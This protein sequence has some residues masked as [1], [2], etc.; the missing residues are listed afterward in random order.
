MGND[1]AQLTLSVLVLVL[2]AGLEELLPKFFGV[3]FPVLLCAVMVFASRRP[4]SRAVLFAIAAGAV[5]DSISSLPAMTSV[6]YFV[7]VASLARW[8]GLPRGMAAFAFC[9]YQAW[10]CAWA[11]GMHGGIFARMLVTLP[12]GLLMAVATDAVLTWAERKA[13]IDEQG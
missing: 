4:A 13:A 5:E 11:G 7:I 3:G 1:L 2:G 6:S 10:L 12:V 8:S 9:G